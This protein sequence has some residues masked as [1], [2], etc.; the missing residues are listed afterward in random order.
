MKQRYVIP[1]LDRAFQV[2]ALL[3]EEPRGLSL[4]DLG[5]RSDIPKSTLFRILTT[6]QMHRCVVW[7]EEQR[8][9]R[10]GSRLLELGTSYLDQADLYHAAARPME[11]LAKECHETVFLGKLEGGQVI[12]LRRMTSPRSITVVKKLGQRVPAHCTATGVAI[13]AFLPKEEVDAIL[14]EHGLPAFNEATL[15]DRKAFKERLEQVRL[16][17]YAIVDGEYNRELICVSAP[18]FDHTRRPCASLTVAMLSSQV[19]EERTKAVAEGVRQ[20]AQAFSREMGGAM[21][22][23]E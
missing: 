5:R 14:E 17:G 4:A 6:L 8:G 16:R 12:Y 10:L 2:L 19:N 7:N 20:V 23:G 3:A 22:D 13:L 1:S 11:T 21:G 15:T 9:Y 18:V